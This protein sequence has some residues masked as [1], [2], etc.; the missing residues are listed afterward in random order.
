VLPRP[1]RIPLILALCL[2]PAPPAR[3]DDQGDLPRIEAGLRVIAGWQYESPR[4]TATQLALL[5]T[6]ETDDSFFLDQ[7]RLR[8]DADFGG[9]ARAVVS[10][11]LDSVPMVRNAYA[12]YRFTRELRLRVGRFRRP[13]ST[14]EMT[15]RGRLPFRERG[16]FNSEVT[17]GS[18]WGDRALGVMLWGKIKK[19]RLRYYLSVSE[20]SGEANNWLARLEARP[21]KWLRIGGGGGVKTD[22]QPVGRERVSTLAAFGLDLRL[23]SSSLEVGIE[24]LGAQNV[25][26]PGI[27][28]GSGEASDESAPELRL[29]WAGGV[30]GY[31]TYD[32]ALGGEAVL[33]P[34]VVAELADTDLDYSRDEAFRGVIGINHLLTPKLRLMPQ[35]EWIEPLAP[36]PFAREAGF[37]SELQLQT[38]RHVDAEVRVSVMVSMEY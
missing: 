16:V 23:R 10:A 30:L 37:D 19:P 34:I 6:P 5:G 18:D 35:L 11:D 33:Q 22:Y 36:A 2:A 9:R 15:N 7:A 29:P 26:P 4:A 14:I 3:A 20:A 8:L 38:Q 21:F 31:V 32:I 27:G 13:Y 17:R 24:A 1:Y 12:G 28:A 25:N